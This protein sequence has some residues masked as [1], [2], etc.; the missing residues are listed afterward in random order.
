MCVDYRPL[1]EVTIKNKY[2]LPWIDILFDQLTGARVF[3]KID[4]R[5]GYHQIHIR[6]EDIPKTAFTTWYGLFEYLVMSFGLTNAPAYLTYLMN[7][8]FMPELDKFVVVFIDDILIY[9][10]NEE[11]HARHLRIVLTR[12]REHQLYAKFSKSAFWLEEIKFLGHVLSAKGIAV[13]PSKVKDILEWKPPTTVQQVRSFLGL[14]GYYRRF[15]PDFSKLVKP[16]T[17]LLKND[18]K[19]NWSLKC[20]EAFKQLKVLLTTAPVLAQL[21]IEKPFDVYCDASGSGLDCVL[22]QEGRVIAYASRQLRWHE[23]HYPTHDLELAAVVH[24]LKIW[25]HYLLGNICHIYT[26]HKSLKY[27][28][29]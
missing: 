5:S 13:D 7:S 18:T 17:S 27:I 24:A 8:V 3:S 10:K 11:E 9:S 4:L 15:I 19:F 23:E 16:I 1:N 22:M 6:P 14:A 2:P 21:D 26:Y 25:R 20:N 29:T 28:F 12:L